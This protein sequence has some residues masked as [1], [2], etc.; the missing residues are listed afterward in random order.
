MS[1]VVHEEAATDE[2]V[3]LAGALAPLPHG[4]SPV[5]DE[6]DALAVAE[7]VDP[8]DQ[9]TSHLLPR[10]RDEFTCSRCFLVAHVSRR[11]GAGDDCCADCA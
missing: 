11:T 6:D 8:R 3:A 2:V 4:P 1:P 5:D 10:Q 7:T 9:D